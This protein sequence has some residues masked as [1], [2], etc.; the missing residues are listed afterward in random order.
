MIATWWRA[1]RAARAARRDPL[2][3]AQ[4]LAG[5]AGLAS[6]AT[7][8][9][10]GPAKAV[11]GHKVLEEVLR[12]P[13]S[14]WRYHWDPPDVRHLGP[15]AQ[16][17]HAAFGLGDNNVTISAT[18]TNGVALVCIQALHRR[19]EDLTA[20]VET[21]REQAARPDRP[22]LAEATERQAGP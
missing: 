10:T 7:A 9:T 18:D 22:S 11:N 14:T 1:A 3:R 12:L 20:Q 19:I 13:V 6:A 5:P 21:L 15:M 8:A 4:V 17:W 2:T 16:D